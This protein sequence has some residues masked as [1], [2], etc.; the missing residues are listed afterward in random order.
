MK[1]N[2]SPSAG[3]RNRARRARALLLNAALAAGAVAVPC[4]AGE[5][6]LRLLAPPRDTPGLFEKVP[7]EVEWRGRPFAKG[8]LAG[9]PVSF[10]RLGLRDRDRPLERAAGTIRIVALGDSVTFGLGVAEEDAYPRVT[11]SL[12]DAARGATLP[13]VEILNFGMP[14][15]NTVHELAQLRETGLAFRPDLVVLGLLYND[16][17]P[18]T[19]QKRHHERAHPPPEAGASHPSLGGRLRARL[20]AAVTLLKEHSLFFAWLSPRLGMVLRPLGGKGL[21]QVGAVKDEYTDSNPAWRWARTALL[22][23]KKACDDE[24]VLLVVLVIPAMA[25]FTESS[26][27]IREYHDALAGV[28]REHA[29]TCLDVLPAFWGQDGTRLWISPTDGHP[30]ARGHRIIAGALAEFLAPLLAGL[31]SAGPSRDPRGPSVGAS[32]RTP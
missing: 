11:E 3:G 12:L 22:E 32:E 23:L 27:P 6:V 2:P 10:N 25:R 26:Y 1:A 21:G 31:P 5:V 7:S 19:D 9:V 28:C 4:L 13:P 17:E 20:N 14:G 24:G 16:I 18:S 29:L 30:D 15:Y 8:L